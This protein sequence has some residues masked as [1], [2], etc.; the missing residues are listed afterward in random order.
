MTLQEFLSRAGELFGLVEKSEQSLGTL[1]KDLEAANT[2]ITTLESEKAD[3]VKQL[4]DLKGQH[5]QDLDRVT[6]EHVAELAKLKDE[7]KASLEAKDKEVQGKA[8][9]KALEI[10]QQQ[11]QPAPLPVPPEK[12]GKAQE[13]AEPSGYQRVVE[14]FKRKQ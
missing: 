1:R 13:T 10:T 6:G 3:L 14:N 8:S 2:K 9:A 11:G 5:T 7:H 4:E 12:G